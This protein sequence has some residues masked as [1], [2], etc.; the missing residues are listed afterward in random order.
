M[1][2]FLALLCFGATLAMAF[3]PNVGSPRFRSRLFE[4]TDSFNMD[5]LRKRI[6]SASNP[7][8]DMVGDMI[9]STNVKVPK[10]KRKEPKSA[11][12][13]FIVGFE[14]VG[15]QH[16]IHSIEYP[17]GLGNNVV[18]AFES[19]QA[20]DKF[21]DS[22]RALHFFDLQVS[23]SSVFLKTGIKERERVL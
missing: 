18:L 10:E 20:C 12:L 8:S 2:R 7:F 6:S 9:S 19:K 11:G 15:D 1:L 5:E 16:G 13:V 3:V 22:L 21:A 14:Q 4:S 17:K 23:R